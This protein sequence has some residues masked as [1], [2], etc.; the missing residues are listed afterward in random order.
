MKK[1]KVSFDFDATLELASIQRYAAELMERDWVEVWITTTRF[2]NGERYKEYKEYN[3]SA[4]EIAVI[5]DDLWEVAENLGIPKERV[6]F[7]NRE[8]KWHYLKGKNFIW[9]LDD[10]WVENRLINTN[11]ESIAISSFGNP[12]WKGK[13]ERILRKAIEKDNDIGLRAKFVKGDV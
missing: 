4:L 6:H 7:T 9:H 2:E 10:D 12:N 11:T 1:Y 13:C 8:D 3:F 5:H